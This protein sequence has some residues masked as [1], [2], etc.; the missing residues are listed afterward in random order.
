MIPSVIFFT[1]ERL[2]CAVMCWML[3]Y[4]DTTD[5]WIVSPAPGI[6][7]AT[8]SQLFRT[9]SGKFDFAKHSRFTVQPRS[10]L[11]NYY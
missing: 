5:T 4:R 8:N 1:R 9:E 10:N 3:Y 2:T 6:L 11:V 7:A